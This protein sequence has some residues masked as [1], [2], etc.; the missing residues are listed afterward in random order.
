MIAMSIAS[1]L[2]VGVTA[3]YSALA[4]VSGRLATAHAGLA[5]EPAPRCRT[6]GEISAAAS[7]FQSRC[8]LPERCAYDVTARS[9]RTTAP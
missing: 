7:R 9:C 1:I 8:A 2:M 4:R 6:S 5:G 3:G